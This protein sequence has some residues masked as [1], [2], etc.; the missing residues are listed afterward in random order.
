MADEGILL[1]EGERGVIVGKS[2]SGK[3]RGAIWQLSETSL[4]PV[5]IFDTK[6][7]P[8][9]NA[10]PR[11]LPDG[12]RE[13]MLKVDSFPEFR[14]LSLDDL[15]EYVLVR[16]PVKDIADP[17]KL[18]EYL[19]VIYSRFHPALVYLDEGYQFHR[20]GQAGEGLIGLLTRGRSRGISLLVGSQRPAWVSQFVFS[21]AT[22]FYIYRL[23]KEDDRARV[24]EFIPGFDELPRVPNREFWYYHGDKDNEP[25]L[26][27]A[28][29]LLKALPDPE[30]AAK[31]WL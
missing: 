24:A 29:P 25:E 9:F 21:E 2:G 6:G 4:S 15:P 10:L 16:P 31:R 20:R 23:I 26:F 28:V 7:E 17:E 14:A 8:A 30:K 27:G 18:D 12:T 19:Q 3:T 13:E 1:G 22:R 11:Q 5:I